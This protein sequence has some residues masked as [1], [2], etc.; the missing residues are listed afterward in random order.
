[1][2]SQKAGSANITVKG[3]TKFKDCF[4]A[5]VFN[6]DGANWKV[7][8]YQN[9][10]K[11]GDFTRVPDGSSANVAAAAFYFN[12]KNKNST[13]WSNSTASHYWYY[14]PASG[15]PSSEKGWEARA[16]QTIPSSGKKNVYSCATLTTNLDTT[17]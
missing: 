16:T 17:F 10:T 4:V 12:V 8:L 2:A 3:N 14:K 7:E 9:G 1:M 5:E 13:T 15:D 6:D 11:I